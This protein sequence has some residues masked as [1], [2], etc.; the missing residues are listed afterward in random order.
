MLTTH[1]TKGQTRGIFTKICV[2]Y[3]KYL[4]YFR[5]LLAI[6]TNSNSTLEMWISLSGKIVKK[7]NQYR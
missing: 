2:W 6:M 1:R 7:I 3:A 4:N 5:L